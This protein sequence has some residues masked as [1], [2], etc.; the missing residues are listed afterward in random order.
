V[1]QQSDDGLSLL[2]ITYIFS[3]NLYLII[4]GIKFN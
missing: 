3:R 1:I 2:V 4:L